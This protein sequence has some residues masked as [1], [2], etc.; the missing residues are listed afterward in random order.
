MGRRFHL[1]DLSWLV[2][3]VCWSFSEYR[4]R[5]FAAA[6]PAI[7]IVVINLQPFLWNDHQKKKKKNS[8]FDNF[9][10]DDELEHSWRLDSPLSLLC[11]FRCSRAF[12]SGQI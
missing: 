6:L 12:K 5:F 2:L 9:E 3:A 10:N 1:W 7:L 8:L 4:A 11:V